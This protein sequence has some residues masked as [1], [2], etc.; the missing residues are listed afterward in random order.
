MNDKTKN[1]LNYIIAFLPIVVFL[2]LKTTTL[3]FRFGDSNAYFYMAKAI[4]WGNIPYRDFFLADPPVLVIILSL[5]RLI[6]KNYLYVYQLLPAIIECVNAFLVYLLLKKENNIFAKFAPLIYLFSFSIISTCDYLTGAQFVVMFLLLGFILWK[7]DKPLLS[8][9]FFAT[10]CLIKL[11]AVPALLGFIVFILLQKNKAKLIKFTT[12]LILPIIIFLFP[13]LIFSY[14][15]T[16]FDIITFHFYRP[17]GLDKFT[18][19]A[20]LISRE[21]LLI[22]LAACGM[23]FA[24]KKEYLLSAIFAILFFVFFQDIYYAYFASVIF[25]FVIFALSFVDWLYKNITYKQATLYFVLIFYVIFILYSVGFYEKTAFLDNRFTNA[26]EISEFVKTIP[27]NLPI[28]GSHQVAPLIA[29]LSDKKLFGNYIDTN[30]Q[31][32]DAK[33]YD[34]RA[35]SQ[36]AVGGGIIMIARIVDIKDLNIHDFGYEKFF[37][38][39]VFVNNCK[40]LKEFNDTGNELTNYIVIYICSKN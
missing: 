39:D 38:K 20:Y 33:T 12:G 35:I 31:I 18:V 5:L 27:G 21:W 13:F 26:F 10:S 4:L 23:F 30:T 28:Y 40:R 37:D 19:F 32:F 2:I 7:N 6:F 34:I 29:L 8:G 9:L 36:Q 15:K 17:N 25:Y 16:I 1:I 11:Y 3:S 14:Q 22:I 24:K